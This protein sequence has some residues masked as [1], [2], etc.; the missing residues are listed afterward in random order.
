MLLH[1]PVL[2]STHHTVIFAASFPLKLCHYRPTFSF[3][4]IGT[5]L[6]NHP[7]ALINTTFTPASRLHP[8]TFILFLL[9]TWHSN[10]SAHNYS[11]LTAPTY[12]FLFQ[13]LPD[14]K[15]FQSYLPSKTGHLHRFLPSIQ[16]QPQAQPWSSKAFKNLIPSFSVIN[17]LSSLLIPSD[18]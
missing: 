7:S 15:I 9:F 14:S 2:Q 13:P 10:S 18:P 3:N 6:S 4:F 8:C 5:A 11:L 1:S 12:L 16:I 17:S